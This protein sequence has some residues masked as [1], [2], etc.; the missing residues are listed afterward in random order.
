LSE[1]DLIQQLISGNEIAFKE[2]YDRFGKKIF[3]TCLNHLQNVEEAEDITQEVFVEVFQSVHKFNQESSLS[4]WIYR[5]AVNKCI[6]QFLSKGRKKRFAFLTSL[7]NPQT[8]KELKNISSFDHPGMELE[9][10]EDAQLLFKAIQLLPKNQHSA[11][12]LTQIEDQSQKEAADILKISEKALESLIQR[13][14]TNIRKHL[15]DYF[16][17]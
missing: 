15:Q 16:K 4:T 9:K 12:I 8:G 7:F 10:K 13:A 6:D 2:I 3:N 5:I 11:F 17:K 1:T 14:K